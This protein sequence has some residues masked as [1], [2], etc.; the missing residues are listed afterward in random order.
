MAA[1]F[2]NSNLFLTD[3]AYSHGGLQTKDLSPKFDNSNNAL[4]FD[5]LGQL[6]SNVAVTA[7][8]LVVEAG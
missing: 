4:H 7:A 2:D 5:S 1:S 8:R 3:L 6:R